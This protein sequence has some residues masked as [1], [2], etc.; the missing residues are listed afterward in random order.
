MYICFGSAAG[1]WGGRTAWSGWLPCRGGQLGMGGS[2]DNQVWL[3]LPLRVWGGGSRIWDA[4][5]FESRPDS[6]LGLS[7]SSD[8][9][10][11]N[12]RSCGFAR[13]RVRGGKGG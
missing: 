11:Q 3:P 10:L 1:K 5:S 7:P 4:H 2:T 12:H 8:K 9:S 13:Q 6:G